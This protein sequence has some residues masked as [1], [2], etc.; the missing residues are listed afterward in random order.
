M[1]GGLAELEEAFYWLELL[2]R[3]NIVD[4]ARL[5]PLRDEADEL[6]RIFVTSTRTAKQ[7][8]HGKGGRMKGRV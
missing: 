6:I 8:P 4:V 5:R 3:T 2:A 1:G 7:E